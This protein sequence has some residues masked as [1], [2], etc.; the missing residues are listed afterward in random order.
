M[1]LITLLKSG[2]SPF[3]YNGNTPPPYAG[4]S[5]DSKLHNSYSINGTPKLTG[6]PT[7]SKLDT[8]GITPAKYKNPETGQTY[9]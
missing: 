9:P 5:R 1:S 2:K 7:P 3:S 8:D 4:G 6:Y